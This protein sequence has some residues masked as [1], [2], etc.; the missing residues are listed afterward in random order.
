MREERISFSLSKLALKGK[1][2]QGKLKTIENLTLLVNNLKW[3]TLQ[4]LLIQHFSQRIS[5]RNTLSLKLS[6]QVLWRI[7]MWDLT[8]N[9][10]INCGTNPTCY[11]IRWLIRAEGHF[12]E[13]VSQLRQW[14]KL[15]IP[16]I[17]KTILMRLVTIPFRKL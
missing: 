16:R 15:K 1:E 7:R 11:K 12:T 4:M 17:Y 14:P 8:T 5:I 6:C 2:W 13:Q 9:S 10:S 3:R